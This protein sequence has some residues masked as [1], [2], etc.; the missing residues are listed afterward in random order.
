MK[1]KRIVRWI[2][3]KAS[4]LAKKIPSLIGL[5][6]VTLLVTNCTGD[7]NVTYQ[8][9]KEGNQHHAS[10]KNVPQEIPEE[11]QEGNPDLEPE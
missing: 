8:N 10:Q 5:T 7:F 11:L 2:W 9:L 4:L 1:S 6:A 3:G